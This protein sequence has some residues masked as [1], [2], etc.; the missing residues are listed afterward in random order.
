MAT[1]CTAQSQPP[2]PTATEPTEQQQSK[3]S[4]HNR[5]AKNRPRGTEGVPVFVKVLPADD[6]Q[7]KGA[8][9]AQTE[10]DDAAREWWAVGADIAIAVLTLVIALISLGLY[11]VAKD[12]ARRQLRAYVFTDPDKSLASFR[13]A[14]GEPLKAMLQI[15][16]TGQTP[17]YDLVVLRGYAIEPRPIREDFDFT[18]KRVGVAGQI[19]PAGATHYWPLS[20]ISG[21]T[22]QPIPA[23]VFNAVRNGVCDLYIFGRIEYRDAFGKQCWTNFCKVIV[24]PPDPHANEFGIRNHIRHN[25]ADQE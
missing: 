5:E 24:L 18:I 21:D 25:D 10:K 8:E 20:N 1:L 7:Q 6:A 17:A 11:L 9:I 12:T 19:V 22:D 3:S 4:T 23:E 16:N 15:K 2:I 14:V 13:F